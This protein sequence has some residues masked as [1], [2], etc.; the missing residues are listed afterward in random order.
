MIKLKSLLTENLKSINDVYILIP[1]I[2]SSVQSVYDNWDQ[3]DPEND[4]LNGGG[5]CQDIAESIADV[6]NSHGID[7]L[8]IDSG[9]V[10]E[11]HVWTVFQVNEGLYQIDIPYQYYETGGGYKWTKIPDVKFNKNMIDISVMPSGVTWE[12]LE[13]YY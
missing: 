1:K 11:Q 9:G 4:D 5:L 8:T 12:D 10:G 3:S 2:I 7:A 6:L 13:N